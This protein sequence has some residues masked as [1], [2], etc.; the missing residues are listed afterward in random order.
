MYMI[1]HNAGGQQSIKLIIIKNQGIHYNNGNRIILEPMRFVQVLIQL[2]FKSEKIILPQYFF[3]FNS[4]VV[5]MFFFF[6]IIFFQCCDDGYRQRTCKPVCNKK[7]FFGRLP[8]RE[9]SCIENRVFIQMPELCFAQ[10]V[11]VAM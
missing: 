2:I 8:M 7:C 1:A 3:S 5:G 9:I 6:E 4:L 10:A 11:Q